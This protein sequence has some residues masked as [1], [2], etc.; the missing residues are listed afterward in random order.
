[1][2]IADRLHS[3][4]RGASRVALAV[5][6]AVAVTSACG[7]GAEDPEGSGA[8]TSSTSGEG[9]G[10]GEGG[11]GQR[12]S[13]CGETPDAPAFEIGTGEICYEPLADGQVV[14]HITGPQGGYHVW[15]GVLCPAC[16]PEVV[17]SILPRYADTGEPVLEPTVR[18]VELRSGQAAGLLAYLTG[19]TLEPGSQLP[20]GTR[21]RI[22]VDLTTLAGDPL[23]AGEKLVE[24][25]E[26]EVWLNLCDPD[27]ATCGQPGGKKCCD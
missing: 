11:S 8:A 3:R 22:A 7:D 21:L 4:S 18:V 20:E 10:A 26:V 9:G 13:P 2:K 15:I 25:G 5:V 14:P 16:P 1:M 24:L 12:P 19:S 17:V 6:A 23:H 27:P